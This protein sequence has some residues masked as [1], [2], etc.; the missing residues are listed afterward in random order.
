[1]EGRSVK[2]STVGHAKKWVTLFAGNPSHSKLVT[3]MVHT[4]L[5]SQR[6]IEQRCGLMMNVF[7]GAFH[8]VLKTE[9]EESV[10]SPYGMDREKFLR[11]GR[12][13]FGEEEF[14]R[15]LYR[16]N[17]VSLDTDLIVAGFD[18]SGLHIFSVRDPGTTRLHDAECF[19]AIGCG[20]SLADAALM[21]TF[22]PLL[23]LTDIIYLL[24]DAKFRSES[25]PGVGKDTHVGVLSEDGSMQTIHRHQIEEVRAIWKAKNEPLVPPEVGEIIKKI[26]IPYPA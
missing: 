14:S 20:A 3:S 17:G 9:I 7:A 13:A 22:N 26:L 6:E 18:N 21:S 5:S 16:I 10:L 1:M 12:A 11:D 25:T 4:S 8:L 19:H 15:I 2:M 23:S 24:M